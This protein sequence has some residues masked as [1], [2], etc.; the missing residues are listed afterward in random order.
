M[1]ISL[2]GALAGV[3]LSLPATAFACSSCGCTLSSDWDSQGFATKSGFRFD[4]RFDYLNQSQLRSGNRAVGRDEFSAP[5]DVEVEN[6]TINRYTTL[7]FDYSPNSNWGINLQL[8]YVD[9]SH[10]TLPEGET[11][12]SFSDSSSVGDARLLLRYQGLTPQKNVGLQIGLKLATGSHHVRFSSGTV[13][14]EPLDRGLQP[15]TGTTN[16]LLG[17]YRF[18][19]LN[20]NWD[21]FAQAM[22]EG[23][24][25]SSDGFRP[26]AS[27]N[28][29]LGL[30]YL[31]NETIVPELQLNSR[32]VRRDS[33]SDADVVNSGGTLVDLSPG[34]TI[35]VGE[36]LHLFGFIQ[37]PVLQ[38]VNG[39]QLAPRYTASIGAR[40]D[41]R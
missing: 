37:V 39:L 35:K 25:D 26:G 2:A 38:R 34:V 32:V 14:G 23:A 5:N 18:G 36:K 19:S 6:E 27:L 12:L 20:Q 30:R 29:N 31:A 8:P 40:Y 10:S 16:L 22:A 21:Y 11:Q 13:A 41:F 15:G 4:I 17:I 28:L 33:G 1:K 7:G 3:L 9:R 24:L